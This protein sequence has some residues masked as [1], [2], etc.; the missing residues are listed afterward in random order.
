MEEYRISF[1]KIKSLECKLLQ[2]IDISVLSGDNV[3]DFV[4]LMYGRFNCKDNTIVDSYFRFIDNVFLYCLMTDE[5]NYNIILICLLASIAFFIIKKNS[6]CLR[7]IN[8]VLKFGIGSKKFSKKDIRAHNNFLLIKL[9]ELDIDNDT[10]CI[11]RKNI[12]F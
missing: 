7:F 11:L 4:R 12:D 8:L 3:F 1:D 10:I 9:K 5:Y 6:C 2:R